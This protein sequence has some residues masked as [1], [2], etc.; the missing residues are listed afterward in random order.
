MEYGIFR[1]R[2]QFKG[3]RLHLVKVQAIVEAPS[4]C[5]I[6]HIGPTLFITS[7]IKCRMEMDLLCHEA[8]QEAKLALVY[9]KVLTYYDQSV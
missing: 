3:Y 2:Y 4:F 9:A 5:Q 6:C 1:A 8:L 7:S